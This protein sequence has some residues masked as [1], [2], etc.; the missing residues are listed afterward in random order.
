MKNAEAEYVI[1][2][3]IKSQNL[4]IRGRRRKEKRKRTKREKE[5]TKR[6][7]EEAEGKKKIK[8]N[9]LD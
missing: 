9:Y 2:K 7:K 3:N 8:K 4:L 1:K 6:E 5:R